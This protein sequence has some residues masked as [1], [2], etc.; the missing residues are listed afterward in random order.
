MAALRQGLQ[1]VCFTGAPELAT[2]LRDM[3]ASAGAR[4][5]DRRPSTVLDLKEVTDPVAACRLWF[6]PAVEKTPP[7]G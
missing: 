6:C 3:A 1:H 5:Y 2:K 7:L 4:L